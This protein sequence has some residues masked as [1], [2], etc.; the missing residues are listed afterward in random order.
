MQNLKYPVKK[1]FLPKIDLG[2][3]KMYKDHSD[4]RFVLHF[5]DEGL[6][7]KGQAAPAAYTIPDGTTIQ[8]GLQ[9]LSRTKTDYG[10]PTSVLVDF[11]NAATVYNGLSLSIRDKVERPDFDNSKNNREFRTYNGEVQNPTITNGVIDAASMEEMKRQILSALENAFLARDNYVYLSDNAYSSVYAR[12]VVSLGDY[13]ATTKL[14]ITAGKTAVV[15]QAATTVVYTITATSNSGNTAWGSPEVVTGITVTEAEAQAMGVDTST[16]THYTVSAGTLGTAG[17]YTFTAGTSYVLDAIGTLPATDVISVLTSSVDEKDSNTKF[18]RTVYASPYRVANMNGKYHLMSIS[19]FEYYTV[20]AAG[21]TLNTLLWLRGASTYVLFEVAT[22]NANVKTYYLKVDIKDIGGTNY[23]N[24]GTATNNGLK[25]DDNVLSLATYDGINFH[26][27]GIGRYPV[28]TP[29]ELA[30]HYRAYN[31]APTAFEAAVSGNFP[32]VGTDYIKYEICSEGT[33]PNLHGASHKNGYMQRV[34]IYVPV[35][36]ALANAWV[37]PSAS[38]DSL[39]ADTAVGA[40]LSF[41]GLLTY[42]SGTVMGSWK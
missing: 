1:I 39:K 21:L 8:E 19:D 28:L 25:N 22:N 41:E 15:N 34:E 33:I 26:S 11:S 30:E 24:T 2:K 14:T 32:I 10:Q 42:F 27:L 9:Y 20:T 16:N 7:V 38:W 5:L 40:D 6:S 18:T 12:K 35:T 17:T 23:Y 4:G 29:R 36:A 37:T 13:T 3:I 31:L